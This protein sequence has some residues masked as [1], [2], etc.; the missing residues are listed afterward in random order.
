MADRAR[1][2]TKLTYQDYLLFPDDGN[3]H[4]IIDG[5]HYTS[6]SP[7]PDHQTVSRWIQFQH[8]EF[9]SGAMGAAVDLAQVWKAVAGL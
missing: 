9:A 6:P 7:S 3:R 8:F 2:D 4:E 5:D 1:A